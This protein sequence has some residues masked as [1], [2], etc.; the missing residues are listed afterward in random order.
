MCCVGGAASKGDLS[1]MGHSESS[2]AAFGPRQGE[3]C[4]VERWNA[5]WGSCVTASAYSSLDFR[6]PGTA[7]CS[8]SLLQVV[9]VCPG[10]GVP[11]LLQVSHFQQHVWIRWLCFQNAQ[12][13]LQPAACA[14][15]PQHRKIHLNATS[16]KNEHL[17]ELCLVLLHRANLAA[18]GVFGCSNMYSNMW[19]IAFTLLLSY[20][21][22]F[23]VK[24]L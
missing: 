3:V 10:S 17:P 16:T 8:I 6:S 5:A 22:I 19:R 2:C 13:A 21:G 23:D 12:G 7:A 1:G 4:S 9:P 24:N 11:G 20:P 18:A 15:F 14:R